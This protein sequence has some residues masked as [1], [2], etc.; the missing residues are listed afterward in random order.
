MIIY[1]EK[2]P[3][4]SASMGTPAIESRFARLAIYDK[5]PRNLPRVAQAF[6]FDFSR[7]ETSLAG[8]VASSFHRNED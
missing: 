7:A 5:F 1:K 2:I 4:E 6:S 3:S 8:W